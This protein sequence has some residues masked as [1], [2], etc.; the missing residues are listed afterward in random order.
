MSLR[1]IVGA[2]TSL[3]MLT[4]PAVAA[5]RAPAH[6]SLRTVA[7]QSGNQRTGRYEEIE[8]LCPAYQQTWPSQVRCFEFG[9]TPEGRP[10]LALVASADGLLDA[11]AAHRAQRPIVLMQ[12]G[13]HAGEPDGKDAGLLALREMLDGT[14]APGALAAATFVFVPV[15][16]VDGHE[17]FGRW[18][19][20]NQVGP[21]EMGWR[22]TAQNLNLNRDYVKADAPEMQAVLRLLNEW[23]PILY[24]DLHVTDGAQFEHDVSYTVS[25]THAGDSDVQ[26]N[27]VAMRDELLQ[28]MRAAGS[29]PVDFYP[30]F[31]R[32]DDPTSGFAVAIGPKRF[33]TEYWAARNRIAVLVETHSWKDYPTRVR[34]TRN[35]IVAMMEM[36]ARD[37]R[38]WQQG[39][40]AADERAARVGGTSVALSY[41][42]TPHVRT[43]EFRGYEYTREPSAVS[44][45]LLTRYNPKKPQIWR[46]PLA[47]EVR[48]AVTVTAPRGGYIV[49][50]GYAQIV[51][52]KL[53][54]HGI[55]FRKL[56][57]ASAVDAEVFR[58]TNVKYSPTTFE[59]HTATSVEGQW[60]RERRN[61]PA[62]SLFVPIAQARS[63]V[64]MTLLEPK[65]PDSLLSWGFFSTAFEPKEYM[66][67]YVAED[68]AEQMLKNDPAL[69]KEFAQRLED[70]AFAHDPAA[71]LGFFYRRHASW[72]ERLNLYPV[73]RVDAAL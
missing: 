38:K 40:Q 57:S 61:V 68:V 41:E 56:A 55:E 62:G 48:P 36:A 71:R 16:N 8:R 66:E 1:T 11:A 17:R 26:R 9:R 12:G 42:N 53:A 22:T 49:P 51:A 35:S 39:A 4:Q 73:Y 27:A 70:P 2:L 52:D 44:G 15:L 43:I 6:A 64:L 69:R 72:D 34:I 13:I 23:D 60:T 19:R 32:D 54:V 24:V 46:I 30:S 10:M 45:A 63:L 58:A 21:E 65:D 29:L 33:S 20:P 31:V 50:A 7:E 25:P 37:G 47:D 14:A 67:Q 28:R 59:G 3:M 5:S 18:N